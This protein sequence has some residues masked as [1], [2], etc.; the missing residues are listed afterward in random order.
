MSANNNFEGLDN[1]FKTS[2]T[3]SLDKNLTAVRAENNEPVTDETHDQQLESDFQE[4]RD[5]LRRTAAYS[6]DAIKGIMHIAK[7]S[8]HPRAYE[9]AGQLINSLQANAKEMLEVQGKQRKI[10]E[11]ALTK[12]KG[13][14]GVTNN[15][16]FVG[17]TKDLLKELS[18]AA[19]EDP[20]VIEG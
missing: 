12:T 11:G 2:P 10:K 7:N 20:T 3:H 1:T 17:S 13:V 14:A 8:D 15:N 18:L 5:I 9:V 16:L 4:A 6:E 19:L